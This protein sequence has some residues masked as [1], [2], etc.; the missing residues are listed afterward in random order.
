MRNSG[1]CHD[2]RTVTGGPVGSPAGRPPAARIMSPEPPVTD[3]DSLTQGQNIRDIGLQLRFMLHRGI[4]CALATVVGVRGVV[5]RKA[6]AVM[7]VGE[8]GE[9]IGVNPD[10]C[11][12]RAI[13]QLAA[14]V[15]STGADR[16]ERYEIDEDAAGYIGLS[17]RISLDV[18]LMRVDAGDRDFDDVLRYL[19]SQAEAVVVVIGTRGVS[20]CAAVGPDRVVGRLDLAELPWPIVQDARRMLT[21]YGHVRRCYS[22]DRKTGRTDVEVWMQSQPAAGWAV[23]GQ[24][25]G[26]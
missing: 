4:S 22:L 19:D 14:Q 10:G 13:Q 16:L 3:L 8:S 24:D 23:I 15:L 9:S 11:L 20:G 6:G 2:A 21:S 17:G 1:I 7:V 18:H 26:I 5:L 12:D 25:A